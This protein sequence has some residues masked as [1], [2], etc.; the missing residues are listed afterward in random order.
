MKI[1]IIVMQKTQ[2]HKNQNNYQSNAVI[3]VQQRANSVIVPAMNCCNQK[4]RKQ[5]KGSI[6]RDCEFEY[7]SA[8]EDNSLVL[9]EEETRVHKHI[10][11]EEENE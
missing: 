9:T 5:I 8:T 4:I 7:D 3:L 6:K 1:L 11:A 10:N 2:M